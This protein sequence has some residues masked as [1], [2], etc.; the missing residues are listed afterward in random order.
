MCKALRIEYRGTL[1]HLMSRGNDGRNIYFNEAGRVLFLE[2]IFS[3]SECFEI[4]F[5]PMFE[6]PTTIIF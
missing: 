3:M 1:Y 6:F 4:N 5:L 2:T